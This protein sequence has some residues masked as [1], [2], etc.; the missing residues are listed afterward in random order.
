M[1]RSTHGSGDARDLRASMLETQVIA[2]R[3]GV[4]SGSMSSGASKGARNH[5]ETSFGLL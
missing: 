5:G 3:F 1:R 4:N 2:E